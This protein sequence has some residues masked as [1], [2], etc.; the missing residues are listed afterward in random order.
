M[1]QKVTLYKIFVASPSDVREERNSLEEII[2]E[3]NLST[4]SRNNKEDFIWRVVP[5]M[6]SHVALHPVT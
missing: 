4:I 5:R 6:K 3:I 1:A 2:D